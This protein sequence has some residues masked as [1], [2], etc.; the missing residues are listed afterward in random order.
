MPEE[1]F[2]YLGV[3][4]GSAFCIRQIV[5]ISGFSQSSKSLGEKWGDCNYPGGQV[6]LQDE[7]LF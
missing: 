4:N 5:S 2:G 3:E 7:D 6:F 1:H